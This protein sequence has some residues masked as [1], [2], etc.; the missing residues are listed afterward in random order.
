MKFMAL[1]VFFQRTLPGRLSDLR[2]QFQLTCEGCPDTQTPGGVSCARCSYEH[3]DPADDPFYKGTVR[4]LSYVCA[5]I[6]VLVSSLRRASS[7]ETTDY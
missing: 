2:L 3:I 7:Q 1:C 6:L 4:Y 5:S